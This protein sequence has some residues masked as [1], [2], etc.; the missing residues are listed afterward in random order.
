MTRHAWTVGL[1][2]CVG[3]LAVAAPAPPQRLATAEA[4]VVPLKGNPREVAAWLLSPQT[5][6]S[7]AQSQAGRACLKGEKD[8]PMW[9]SKRL[10]AT[11]DEGRKSV[12]IRLADCPRADA[13]ALLTAVVDA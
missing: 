10:R 7:L 11:V 2:L 4:V 3:P 12:T 1:A 9:L 8:I 13:V 6:S 5:L